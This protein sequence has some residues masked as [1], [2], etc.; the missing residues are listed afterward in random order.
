MASTL[1]TTKSPLTKR[2]KVSYCVGGIGRDMAYNLINAQILSFLMLTRNLDD[3]ML[4][5]ITVIMVACRIFDGLNDPI[6]GAIIENT[7]HKK[8]KFKPWILIGALTNVAV[9][10]SIYAVNLKGWSYV[11]FFAFAY[12]LWG[13]TYTMNDIA[14]W[15]MLPSLSTDKGVRDNLSSWANLLAGVGAGLASAG[16]P[17]FSV[18]SLAIV[19]TSIS[20]SYLIIAAFICLAF[21]GCQ[22]LTYF[23]TQHE[24]TII[25]NPLENKQAKKPLK[26]MWNV[27]KSNDQ[28][29]WIALTMFFYNVGQAMLNSAITIYIYITFGFEGTLVT[30]FTLLY[31]VSAALPMIFYGAL[32]KRFSRRNMVLWGTIMAM[33]GYLLFFLTGVAWNVGDKTTLLGMN[34]EWGNFIVLA[35]CGIF[36]NIGQTL[37]YNITTI[38]ISNCI[39]Y[40]EWKTGERKEG[41]IFALRPLM[42]K[43]GSAAQLGILTLIYILLG[44]NDFTN[45]ISRLDGDA[46]L[47]LITQEEKNQGVLNILNSFD[48]ST[49]IKLKG[50]VC[51]ISALFVLAAMFIYL[52]KFKIDEKKYE[53]MLK[54]INDR[55]AEKAENIAENTLENPENTAKNQYSNQ[56]ENN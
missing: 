21:V 45:R 19:K 50:W 28:V 33:V 20:Y 35:L 32:S 36:I 10:I 43:I 11:I 53:N 31:G 27:I 38:S 39:E 16:I 25:V 15:S 55:K 23:G 8:G 17:M 3:K 29:R 41:V 6:M 9:I 47:G 2:S 34:I 5:V 51:L 18:G 49:G 22:L 54:D 40:N 12:L 14:Y 52:F 48:Q 24:S 7:H 46:T 30:I 42:A 4:A 13:I 1:M 56:K 44:V 26:D 37:F